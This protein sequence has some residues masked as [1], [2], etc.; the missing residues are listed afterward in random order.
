MHDKLTSGAAFPQELAALQSL[1]VDTGRLAALKAA[2]DGAPTGPALAAAFAEVAPA[3]LAA[4][5]SKT[6]GSVTDRFLDH[7]RGLV[8]VHD[9]HET[10]GDDPGALV[11]QVEA[12]SR[13]GDLAGALAAF[14]KLPEPSRK[15]AAAWAAEAGQAA[16]AAQALQAIRDDAIGH[17]T[18]GGKS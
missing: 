9:L 16:A 2:V 3:V 18:S 11:T 17:L 8:V 5:A 4:A 12:M 7:L 10:A 13:R 15:A 6:G 14:G 1:G